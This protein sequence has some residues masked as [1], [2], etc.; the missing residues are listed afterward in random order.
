M[1]TI[2]NHYY[3]LGSLLI[4]CDEVG[5]GPLAGPVVAGSVSIDCK[6]KSDF[7]SVISSL[8]EFGVTDS[9]KLTVKRREKILNSLGV[10]LDNLTLDEV[11][12]IKTDK[13]CQL[14]FILIDKSHSYIDENNILFASLMAMEESA[15]SLSSG[16]DAVVLIDGNKDFRN[17]VDYFTTFPITKGDSKSVIIGLA[18]IIAK[19]YRDR[20]MAKYGEI[21]PGYGLESHAGYPTL[22]HREAIAKLGPTPIHRKSFKGVKEYLL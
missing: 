20:L 12:E 10:N 14:S 17:S 11:T 8:K 13:N 2:D 7:L 6:S 1:L 9:K 16:R 18:S 19:E 15:K 21:Y 3:K 22:K 4:G 5:R